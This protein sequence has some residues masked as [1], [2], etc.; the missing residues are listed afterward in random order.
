MYKLK[1]ILPV[2]L[3]VVIICFYIV[4]PV[5]SSAETSLEQQ[6]KKFIQA[7]NA[8]RTNNFKTFRKLT[9]ELKDYPLHPYL[10]QYYLSSNLWKVKDE[11]IIEFLERYGDLTTAGDLRRDW[12]KYLAKQKR[13]QTYVE[14]YT[15]QRNERLKC[16]HLHARLQT[17]NHA[18][19]LED[20]RSVWL[21][22]KS[23]PP[24]CD[25][26]FDLLYKSDLLT[27]ELVWKRIEL[28]MAEG[29][30][31]LAKYLSRFLEK[32]A[33]KTWVSRW[34][35][36]HHNPSRW[37]KDR[38]YED[39][40]IAREILVHGI[41]RLARI[42]INTAINRWEK[43]RPHYSFEKAQVD[44][45][46]RALAIRVARAKLDNAREMLEQI[47]N[48]LVDGDIFHWRLSTALREGDWENLLKWTTGNPPPDSPYQRWLYW[49]GR[50]LEET[51]DK[52][53]ATRAFGQISGERDYYGFLARDRLGH[54]YD[55]GHRSLPADMEEWYKLS[56]RPAIIRARELHVLG[57]HYS[58]RRE[59]QHA[60]RDMT[61]YQ[62]QIAAG[63]AATWGW[64]DQTIVTLGR[65]KAYD[66]LILRFPMP[67]EN[68]ITSNVKKRDLDLS[69]VYA[70]T[71]AESSFMEDAKSP[72]GAMGLMQVMPATARETA[73]NLGLEKFYSSHLLKAASNVPIG[74]EYLRKM[75][76]RFNK[77][78]I[79]ATAAYNAGPNAVARWL[80][81]QGCID[82]EIWI[83]QIPY[84][85]T[86]RYVRRILYFA[87]IYDWR[88]E[89]EIKP[90]KQRMVTVTPVRK[91]QVANL[92]C[93]GSNISASL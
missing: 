64:H 69:W 3:Q 1:K 43:L 53:S 45:I 59:W 52:E 13:W 27:G 70:L 11:E 89:Q 80:P 73:R 22:G 76:D 48:E 75:Y 12:L 35:A 63:I 30:T 61:S 88:L 87:S 38:N 93:E 24:Q 62:L 66:D 84:R 85:E 40:P 28:A 25:A 39:I 9:D 21:S 81:E 36:V 29:N 15:P 37:T 31:S 78:I 26:A 58:A 47:P 77:N 10:I 57:M 67:Y 74:T 20:T 55:L 5:N 8:L 83:E 60:F 42:D 7:Q 32:E 18:Y 91:Q 19:L 50:A 4:A 65:A 17:N 86:R 33:D 23:L 41:H 68:L 49:H 92:T 14:N 34:I 44:S 16:Y 6:R 51:G 90:V 79:V 46:R 2:L 71:R 54:S 82:P 56:R 72:A